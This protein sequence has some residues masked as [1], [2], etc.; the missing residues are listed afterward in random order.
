MHTKMIEDFGILYNMSEIL[1]EY[2]LAFPLLL[3]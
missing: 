2:G 1:Q 3:R